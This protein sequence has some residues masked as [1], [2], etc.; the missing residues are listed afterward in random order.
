[1]ETGRGGG[2]RRRR[3]E[4]VRSDRREA[5]R[6]DPRHG[7][8][9]LRFLD[10]DRLD[11]VCAATARG[12]ADSCIFSRVDTRAS[13]ARRGERDDGLIRI[14][15]R[16]RRCAWRRD[17]RER[18]EGLNDG[19]RGKMVSHLRVG[20][21]RER[22][23]R[24]RRR[25]IGRRGTGGRGGGRMQSRGRVRSRLGGGSSRCRSPWCCA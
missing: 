5:S 20:V 4:T 9:S 19:R 22:R 1:M 14:E 23:L 7:R 11:R 12:S 17:R 2:L 10:R 24:H 25:R 6:D 15:L 8:P 16:R 13:R 3:S 18:L 21:I